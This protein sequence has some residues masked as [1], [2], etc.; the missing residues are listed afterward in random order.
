MTLMI[1]SRRR[2]HR[3]PR[4]DKAVQHIIKYSSTL[5]ASTE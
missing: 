4:P 5:S 3:H 1:Y 2:I